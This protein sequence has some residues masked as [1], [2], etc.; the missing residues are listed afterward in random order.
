MNQLYYGD[1]IDVLKHS[2]EDASIDLIYIDPPFNSK[3]AYNVLFESVDLTDVKAQKE[4]FAD[5]WSN[6]SYIDEMN[7]IAD[8]NLGLYS[9]LRTLDHLNLSKGAASYL[10]T[11]A[12]RIHFMH[13]KLK[14]TGSFYLH[15]DPT[16]SHYLK[17][18]MDLIFGVKNFR[19]E[20]IWCYSG[21]GIPKKDFP[22]KHDV[23][24][25]YSK[26]KEYYYQPVYRP[27]S[28]GT[29]QRGRTQVK[30]K[31]YKT[32]LR[33]EGT[34]VTDWWIDVPKITSPTDP[35]KMG[36]PTQKPEALLERIIRTSSNEGDLV[37]DFFCGC[38]TTI[39]VAQKLNRKWIGVD[40]SHLA[41]RLIYDRLLKP[42]EEQ[43]ETY[44]E[45]KDN[46]EINGFPKDIAAAKDL[47]KKTK[48][49]PFKFQD[50]I[51]EILLRGVSNPK[52]TADGGYDGYI[53][54]LKSDKDKGVILIEVKSGN[55]SVKN[56]REFID[57]V[58]TENA[59]IGI[60]V[61][62]KEQ[63]TQPMLLHAKQ[64]GYFEPEIFGQR[65]DK[66]QIITVEDLLAG[67]L[68]DY[69]SYPNSTFKQ[70]PKARNLEG[71]DNS[72]SLFE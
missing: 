34:P 39:A 45:I 32:G 8:L 5:T 47:A 43:A 60:F 55:V 63:V 56:I 42:Y 38:G 37:A 41:I 67:K 48:K 69:P 19:N 20:I 70:A 31:Y 40:I 64:A 58:N 11:M 71:A 44:Q 28:S 68:I 46:I 21:G 53:T 3:R 49:G 22:R 18:V 33:Q 15:C 7:E 9:F 10:T 12:L 23:V 29:V 61:C 36:Y 66:I 35:E 1:N 59:A 52:K 16:M 6:V 51:I 72:T 2:I 57:V 30:G 17:I 26:G 14:D 13:K 50:W 4:A 27:Y 62:F 25:R 65:Y 54:F 24:L